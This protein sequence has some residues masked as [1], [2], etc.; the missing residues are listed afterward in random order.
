MS[1]AENRHNL[2]LPDLT[3]PRDIIPSADVHEKNMQTSGLRKTG[4]IAK[5]HVDVLAVA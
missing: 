1:D 2:L 3:A 5:D 4:L